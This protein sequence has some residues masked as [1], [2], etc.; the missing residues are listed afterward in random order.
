MSRF[1]ADKTLEPKL[2]TGRRPMTT[3]GEDRM[4]VKMSLKYR[5][6]TAT[7]LSHEFCVQKGKLISGKN[8]FSLVK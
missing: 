1:K 5:L 3:K 4:I 7:P 2:G 8:Y 6:V